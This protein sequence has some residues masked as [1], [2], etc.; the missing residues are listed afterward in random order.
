MTVIACLPLQWTAG[1]RTA[2]R[3]DI[4]PLRWQRPARDF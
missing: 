2:H 1:R 3:D 4:A